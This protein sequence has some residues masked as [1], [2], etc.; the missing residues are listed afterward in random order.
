MTFAEFVMLDATSSNKKEHI[1][2]SMFSVM[3]TVTNMNSKRMNVSY[4]Y[5]KDILDFMGR[6]CKIGSMTFSG[7]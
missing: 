4:V 5:Y 6:P 7:H 1:L 3:K 2:Q